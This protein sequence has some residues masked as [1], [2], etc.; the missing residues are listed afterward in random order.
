V[1]DYIDT[2]AAAKLVATELE[3]NAL[4]T[5]LL[6]QA[7]APVAS[8]LTRTELIRTTRRVAPDLAPNARA[9][10]D[11]FTL[12]TVST[13][14]FEQAAL[15]DPPELRTLDAVH[16]ACALSLGDDLDHLITYDQRLADA[17]AALGIRVLSPA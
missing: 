10:L 16:L 2:S 5:Y 3:T 14:L 17:A 11:T 15:L 9:V 6:E 12:L 7:T 4:R 13:Q 8:D 1:P